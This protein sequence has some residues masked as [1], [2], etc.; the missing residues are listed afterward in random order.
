MTSSVVTDVIPGPAIG[1]VSNAVRGGAVFAVFAAGLV[2]LGSACSFHSGAPGGPDGG[3]EPGMDAIVRNPD[4]GYLNSDTVPGPTD[5]TVCLQ[6]VQAV[7]RDFRGSPG[8]NNEPKHPDFEYVTGPALTGIAAAMIGPDSKPVYAPP[9]PTAVTHGAAEYDQWYRDVPGVNMRFEI[10]LPLA[11]DP[12]RPGT[13]VYDNSAFFPLDGMGF[14]NEDRTHNFHFTSEMHF[15]FPYRGGEVFTFKGDDDVWLF[16]NGHLA[17][18]LGG[19]HGVL[20]G[21]VNLDQS[22]TALGITPGNN[23]R[24][25]IFHAE[26]HTTRSNFRIETTLQC[27][28]NVVIF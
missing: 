9:G 26:R 6:V 1:A 15:D 13:F 10:E 5:A 21:T 20:T 3:S 22:A 19:V 25:D 23:Y 16:V 14:G 24:M 4:V 27:I 7:V 2:T 18:D 28:N 11:A 8:P 12:A 17:I